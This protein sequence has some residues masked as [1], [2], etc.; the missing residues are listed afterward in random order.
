MYSWFNTYSTGIAA[1]HALNFG[2]PLLV[3]IYLLNLVFDPSQS[4]MILL[5]GLFFA[6]GYLSYIFFSLAS[7]ENY[8]SNILGGL[9]YMLNI[10]IIGEWYVPNPWFILAYTGLPVTAIGC[11]YLVKK[12]LAWSPFINFWIFIYKFRVCEYAIYFGNNFV[13]YFDCVLF[14]NIKKKLI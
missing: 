7:P 4:Q 8:K 1:G 2:F 6:S 9:F 10:V 3:V 12:L 11:Y 13:K 5:T 14:W